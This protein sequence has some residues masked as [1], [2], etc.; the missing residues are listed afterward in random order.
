MAANFFGEWYIPCY[1]RAAHIYVG[2]DLK[3]KF[4]KSLAPSQRKVVREL[5]EWLVLR[6]NK[7]TLHSSN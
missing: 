7:D 2:E 1:P 3:F 6:S 5:W 4:L